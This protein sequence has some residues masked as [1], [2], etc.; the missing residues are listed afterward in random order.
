MDAIDPAIIGIRKIVAS[1]FIFFAIYTEI[2]FSVPSN[3]TVYAILAI[4]RK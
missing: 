4:E 3:E 2:T 1:S